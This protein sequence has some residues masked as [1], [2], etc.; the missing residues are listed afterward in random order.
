M[1]LGRQAAERRHG[2]Q[3]HG[4]VVVLQQTIELPQPGAVALGRQLAH[5][6]AAGRAEIVVRV[7]E[8]DLETT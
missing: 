8:V 4:L 5:Q 2:G 3:A 6:L 7:R 1:R